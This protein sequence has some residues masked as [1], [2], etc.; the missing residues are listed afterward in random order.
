MKPGQTYYNAPLMNSPYFG[1]QVNCGAST[2]DGGSRPG[3]IAIL[4]LELAVIETSGPTV[5]SA[6]TAWQAQR[7]GPRMV[8]DRVHGRWSL[9]LP[10]ERDA[11]HDGGQPDDLP[12]R[13]S[14]RLAPVPSRL[15]LAGRRH[16]IDRIGCRHPPVDVG[17]R[18][19]LRL[20]GRPLHSD[21]V[22]KSVNIDNAPV[23][24][25]LTGPTDAPSTAGPQTITATASAGPSGVRGISCSVDGVAVRVPGWRDR[26]DPGRRTRRAHR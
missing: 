19:G 14:D 12:T 23:A 2:C 7:L 5:T 1:W 17:E 20:P 10:D 13:Q 18:R 9:S 4:D 8:A 6:H 24:L 16:G 3:E 26:A 25:S 22:T 21:T 11:R 15:V